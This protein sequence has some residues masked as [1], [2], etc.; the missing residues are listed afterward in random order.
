MVAP[1]V[2]TVTPTVLAY[3][4]PGTAMAGSAPTTSAFPAAG[5]R[6]SN[7]LINMSLSEVDLGLEA[8]KAAGLQRIRRGS[9]DFGLTE[10]FAAA[11]S[12]VWTA[13]T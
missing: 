4:I 8:A 1:G 6:R 12:Q 11:S 13:V 3:A 7:F 9:Q 10:V 2:F 5:R